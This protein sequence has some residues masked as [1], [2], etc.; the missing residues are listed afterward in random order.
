MRLHR[1][2]DGTVL[3]GDCPGGGRR[4]RRFWKGFLPLAATWAGWLLAGE[5]NRSPDPGGV[6]RSPAPAR[7][8]EKC[9]ELLGKIMDRDPDDFDRKERREEGK[10][11]GERQADD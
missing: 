9:R 1:R 5:C 3:T 8:R 11:Q 7:G 10:G 2:P 6:T 4:P